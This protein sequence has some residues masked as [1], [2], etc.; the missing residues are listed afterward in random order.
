[1]EP[2]INYVTIY[3]C[4]IETNETNR[5]KFGKRYKLNEPRLIWPGNTMFKLNVSFWLEA[6]SMTRLCCLQSH[7]LVSC[8][9]NNS[10]SW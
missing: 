4:T 1:M 2:F 8:S 6:I 7:T 5:H 10:I 3:W 9:F